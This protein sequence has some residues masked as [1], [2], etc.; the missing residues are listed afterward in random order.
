[1][2]AKYN[3]L[4]V[5]DEQQNL[6]AF[7]AMFR[8]F[9]NVYIAEGGSE[10]LEIM[11]EQPV[12]LVL[13][14]QRM[15]RM[16]GV[17]L[18]ENVMELYPEAVRIIVTGYSEMDPILNAIEEGKIEPFLAERGLDILTHLNNEEIEK[19]F[20]MNANG[21]LI[22]QMTGHFRFVTASSKKER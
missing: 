22:G 16:T 10:A 19:T 6:R 2:T 9:F 5:D 17:E 8:R 14:D 1:M 11:K 3:I 21:S 7:R 15:P 13:S 18:C 20:L 4:Y 12:D